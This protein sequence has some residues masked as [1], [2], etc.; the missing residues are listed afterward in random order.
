VAP[1][2]RHKK[3]ASQ[4]KR[5]ASKEVTAPAI[6][7]AREKPLVTIVT[8]KERRGRGAYSVASA[9]TLGKAEPMPRPQRNGR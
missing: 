9:M 5:G 6:I 4:P 2:R 1:P 3:T 8:S 7:R